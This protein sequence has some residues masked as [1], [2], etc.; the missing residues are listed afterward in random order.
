MCPENSAS[1]SKRERIQTRRLDWP[2]RHEKFARHGASQ[3]CTVPTVQVRMD[4]RRRRVPCEPSFCLSRCPETPCRKKRH[5]CLAAR[6]THRYV[7]RTEY[8]ASVL[9]ARYIHPVFVFVRNCTFLN[10]RRG[11]KKGGAAMFAISVPNRPAKWGQR[12]C[13]PSCKFKLN[14]FDT[15]PLRFLSHATLAPCSLFRQLSYVRS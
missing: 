6:A 4:T 11:Q 12:H 10:R 7:L 14:P 13:S 1:S 8:R 2:R 3:P 15:H 9:C 5:G